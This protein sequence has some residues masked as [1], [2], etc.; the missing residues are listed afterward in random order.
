MVLYIG[1]FFDWVNYQ[2]LDALHSGM[3]F[4]TWNDSIFTVPYGI[5]YAGNWTP[6][7][8]SIAKVN[9]KIYLGGS[10]VC[11][12]NLRM[13][14]CITW[15]SNNWDSVGGELNI[16]VH[17]IVEY[18]GRLY[19]G[20][21]PQGGLN[22]AAFA[23]WSGNSWDFM[24]YPLAG[25]RLLMGVNTLT[26]YNGML[27]VG[28]Q[29]DSADGKPVNSIAAFDGVNWYSLV[30]GVHT[31]YIHGG[32]N[33]LLVQ[34]EK[35]YIGGAFDSINNQAIPN[36]AVWDGTVWSGL[37]SGLNRQVYALTCYQGMLYAGGVFDTAG[38]KRANGIACW[39]DT[40]WNNVGSGVYGEVNSM[41]V[42]KGSLYV[43]GI[44]DSA[45]GI[46]CNNLARWT[47]PW[48]T[49]LII[50]GN[51]TT[52][53]PNPNNGKFTIESS[54][55]GGQTTVN[56]YNILDRIFIHPGF[57]RLITNLLSIWGSRRRAF[58]CIA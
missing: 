24:N 31:N 40:C 6:Y 18:K 49:D 11:G 42:Y 7:V 19:I 36:I 34:G 13:R 27:I 26:V 37:G 33:A 2:S 22:K 53:F 45:G 58:T 47:S 28:G 43:G 30:Q 15:N 21:H 16:E 51:E 41:A 55:L 38:G 54:A 50:H 35:L 25:K 14:N 48:T 3:S 44:F 12:R 23:A 9:E 8:Y 1:G 5:P 52:L 10:F 32:V 17:A 29:F 57:F 46:H 4:A 56:I 20:G 39:N